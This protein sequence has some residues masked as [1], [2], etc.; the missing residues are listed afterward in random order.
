MHAPQTFHFKVFMCHKPVMEGHLFE[1]MLMCVSIVHA[2]VGGNM[3]AQP[4]F[5]PS[6][7]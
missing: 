4:T 3:S 6:E 7:F 5:F 2:Y 1:I